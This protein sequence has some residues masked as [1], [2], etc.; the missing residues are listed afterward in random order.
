M[1]TS[2]V[3]Y[4]VDTLNLGGTETQVVQTAIHM[5]RRG[6]QVVVGCLSMKG[7]LLPVLQEAGIPVTQFNKG[8][9][10]LS[11]NGFLQ[12]VRLALFL[13]CNKFDVLHAY[14]LWANLLAIPAAWLARTPVRIASRRYL[15]DLDW[16]SPRRRRVMGWIYKLSTQVVVNA[17]AVRDLLVER[18]SVASDRVH[19]SL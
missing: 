10:L 3:L 15:M 17:S 1:E 19:A 6:H 13:R 16:Y 8:K 2:R 18:D 4:M 7:P 9:T 5:Q 14:D 11:A 12:L